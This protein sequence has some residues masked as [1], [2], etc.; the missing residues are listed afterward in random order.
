MNSETGNRSGSLVSG[1]T[2]NS[3]TDSTFQKAAMHLSTLPALLKSF[4]L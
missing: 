1:A 3:V 4:S 2:W